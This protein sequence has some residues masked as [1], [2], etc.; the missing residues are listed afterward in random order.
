MSLYWTVSLLNAD[1]RCLVTAKRQEIEVP[2]KMAKCYIVTGA[3]SAR[4]L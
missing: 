1:T 3:L 4:H 2:Q